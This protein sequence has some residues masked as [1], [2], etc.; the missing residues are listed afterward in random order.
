MEFWCGAGRNVMVSLARGGVGEGGG[1]WKK[2]KKETQRTDSGSCDI[3]TNK[4]VHLGSV[5]SPG[6][7]CRFFF[8]FLRFFFFFI[9]KCKSLTQVLFF[10]F[11]FV[12]F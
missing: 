12:L 2:K 1:G 8:V 9:Q 4:C 7:R 3:Y 6:L 10:L 11:C 5:N